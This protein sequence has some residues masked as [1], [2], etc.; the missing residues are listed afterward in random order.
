MEM[1]AG[2]GIEMPRLLETTFKQA[3]KAKSKKAENLSLDL[4]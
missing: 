2:K 1:L 4:G 3:P